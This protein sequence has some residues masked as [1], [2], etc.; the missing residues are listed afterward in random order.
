MI[1]G[2]FL[3]LERTVCFLSKNNSCPYG[4]DQIVSTGNGNLEVDAMT[5]LYVIGCLVGA[6]STT[7]SIASQWVAFGDEG[8]GQFHLAIDADSIEKEGSRAFVMEKLTYTRPAPHRGGRQIHVIKSQRIFDC[9]QRST[10][11]SNGLAY[12]DP[13]ATLAI[14]RVSYSDRPS[15]YEKVVPGSAEERVFNAVCTD[16]VS[17][18]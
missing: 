13:D 8:D 5:R 18:P 1:S 6:L 9:A 11:L 4:V 12:G 10:L 7:P 17:R 16:A 14:D 3:L 15:N 2:V